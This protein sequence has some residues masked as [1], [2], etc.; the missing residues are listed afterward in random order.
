MSA[1]FLCWRSYRGAQAPSPTCVRTGANTCT[2]SCTRTRVRTQL[3][4][5]GVPATPQGWLGSR[6]PSLPA[7]SLEPSCP[8]SSAAPGPLSSQLDARSSLSAEPP[9]LRPACSSGDRAPEASEP[10]VTPR[11]PRLCL[12]ALLFALSTCALFLEVYSSALGESPW[13]TEPEVLLFLTR[14]KPFLWARHFRGLPCPAQSPGPPCAPSS[15]PR[16]GDADEGLWLFLSGN[17]LPRAVALTC[18]EQGALW[19]RCPWR[20]HGQGPASDTPWPL[21]RTCRGSCWDGGDPASL[22]ALLGLWVHLEGLRAEA[23]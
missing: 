22:P 23:L 7:A 3:Q 14:K 16:V 17:A 2:H 18:P 4:P 1:G 20:N 8:G 19:C 13:E 5:L 11:R 9:S 10:P 6:V 12:P 21:P 15:W